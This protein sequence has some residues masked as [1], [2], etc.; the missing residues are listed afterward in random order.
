[1]NAKKSDKERIHEVDNGLPKEMEELREQL[2]ASRTL[3][4]KLRRNS[5]QCV[6]IINEV[7]DGIFVETIQGRILDVN[8]AGCRMLG[9]SREELLSMHVGTLV[10][11]QNAHGHAGLGTSWSFHYSSA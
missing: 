4:A 2:T 6:K 8:E 3:V 11:P 5:E 7:K 1:M 9:Y 10:P